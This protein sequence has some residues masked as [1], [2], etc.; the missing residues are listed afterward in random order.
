MNAFEPGGIT[1]LIVAAFTLWAFSRVI[2]RAGYSP[3]W[4][5]LGVVPV[6][7]VVMLWVFAFSKWPALPGE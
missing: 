2:A 5:L 7:N 4:A 6:V 3:W 1:A